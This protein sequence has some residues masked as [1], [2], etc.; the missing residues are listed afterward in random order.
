MLLLF[1]L[2][3]PNYRFPNII[4]L[5]EREKYKLWKLKILMF[6]FVLLFTIITQFLMFSAK[7]LVYIIRTLF[8]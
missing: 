2:E 8:D 6:L 5:W 4:F 7:S 3:V 1:L